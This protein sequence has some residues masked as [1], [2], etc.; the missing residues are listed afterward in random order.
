MRPWAL[1]PVKRFDQGKSRLGEVLDDAARAEVARA[2]FDRV[3]Q[4]R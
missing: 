1:V 3:L 4:E 2:M